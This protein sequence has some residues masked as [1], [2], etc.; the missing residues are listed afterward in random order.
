MNLH[1]RIALAMVAMSFASAVTSYFTVAHLLP[2]QRVS[3][4]SAKQGAKLIS[5]IIADEELG[6]RQKRR[7]VRRLARELRLHIAEYRRDGSRA[8]GHDPIFPPR[9]EA[10]ESGSHPPLSKIR[11]P[12]GRTAIIAEHVRPDRYLMRAAVLIITLLLF[13][14]GS[15]LLA[16]SI[17]KKLNVLEKAVSNWAHADNR[18]KLELA[19][20]DEE[21]SNETARLARAF[22]KAADHIE[23]LMA[24]QRRTVA[25][26]SHELRTPLGRIQLALGSVRRRCARKT[27]TA[28][29]EHF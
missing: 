9:I 25:S 12:R 23:S 29:R 22:N 2:Q 6:P 21:G 27:C 14:I 8:R 28:D 26:A 17:T 5:Q 10:L 3:K 16:R 20:V 15:Y 18:G 4:V 1:L 13:L 24:A 19:R 7:Q 11:L